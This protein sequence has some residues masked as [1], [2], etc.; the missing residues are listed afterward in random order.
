MQTHATL[1]LEDNGLI[2]PTK[3]MRRLVTHS[4]ARIGADS[5]LVAWAFPDNHGH[6]A[7]RGGAEEA[8]H[9]AWRVELA[10][11]AY[12][13]T[14]AGA[15]QPRWLRARPDYGYLRNTTRYILDQAA[16]HGIQSDPFGESDCRVDVLGLRCVVPWARSRIREALPRLADDEI[17]ETLG[18][19]LTALRESACPIT[20]SELEHL[21]EA[22]CAVLAV[23]QLNGKSPLCARA[24][25]AAVLTC[26]RSVRTADIVAALGISA[27]GV[28]RIRRGESHWGE[29][30]LTDPFSRPVPR[31]IA[32]QTRWRAARALSLETGLAS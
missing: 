23:N 16:H 30:W 17:A 6:L 27:H 13:E 1:R 9:L 14:G 4:I 28:R 31:A 3:T 24:R 26:D 32:A 10:I 2:C 15:F 5:P 8:S 21:R 22:T 7:V 19:S 11:Q 18:L 20:A 25:A 12:R 29:E